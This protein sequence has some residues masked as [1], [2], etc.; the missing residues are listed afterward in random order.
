[1][2]AVAVTVAPRKVRRELNSELRFELDVNSCSE[3]RRSIAIKAPVICGWFLASPNDIFK[4]K[5]FATKVAQQI[6]RR[7][8]PKGKW[9]SSI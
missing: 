6:L 9:E 5:A 2:A 4:A 3:G 7:A 8:R 1:M